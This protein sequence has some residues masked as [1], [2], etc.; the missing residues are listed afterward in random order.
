MRDHELRE[1][2][3]TRD[4]ADMPFGRQTLSDLHLF[5]K[6][7]KHGD[8]HAAP[9]R[10]SKNGEHGGTEMGGADVGY[11]VLGQAPDRVAIAGTSFVMPGA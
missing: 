1:R 6:K 3:E 4:E 11:R 5:Q 9:S 10:R 2:V 7:G 8:E